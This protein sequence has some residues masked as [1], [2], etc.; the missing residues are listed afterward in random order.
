MNQVYASSAFPVASPEG[1]SMGPCPLV[2]QMKVAMSKHKGLRQENTQLS[3]CTDYNFLTSISKTLLICTVVDVSFGL[4]MT[5]NS[6]F[7][8]V[9]PHWPPPGSIWRASATHADMASCSDASLH[10]PPMLLPTLSTCNFY[11]HATSLKHIYVWQR[12]VYIKDLSFCAKYDFDVKVGSIFFQR[13]SQSRI[14]LLNAP[15]IFL[16]IALKYKYLEITVVLWSK[17]S[18]SKLSYVVAT[19]SLI[20]THNLSIVC[21]PLFACNTDALTCKWH[22]F[23]E[24]VFLRRFWKAHCVEIQIFWYYNHYSNIYDIKR[25]WFIWHFNFI[26]NL[27]LSSNFKTLV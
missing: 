12:G 21:L 19:N 14:N 20:W 22:D 23:W 5:R 8:R 13:A 2:P 17:C 15:P 26:F 9:S 11:G 6:M 24:L 4:E 7:Q 16:R 27:L 10:L 25:I 3:N 1:R 18:W